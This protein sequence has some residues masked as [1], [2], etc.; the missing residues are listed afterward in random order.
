MLSLLKYFRKSEMVWDDQAEQSLCKVP[1]PM[2]PMVRGKVEE[3]VRQRGGNKVRARDFDEA[4]EAFEQRFK[5]ST[6][7]SVGSNMPAPNE[8]GVPMTLVQACHSRAAGCKN[9]L[10]DTDE[11]KEAVEQ[12]VEESGIS[13]RLRQR[14]TSDTIFMHNKIRFS[15]SGC[16]NGCSRPQIADFGIVGTVTPVFDTEKCTGCGECAEACPDN[17]IA[18]VHD[19]AVR[20]PETC[21]GCLCCSRACPAECIST[22]EPRARLLV[23][24]KLGRHPHLADPAGEFRTPEE[25]LRRVETILEEYLAES[26]PG[27]RFAKYWVEKTREA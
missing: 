16:P 1:A 13:E 5:K 27:E 4:K 6:G 20:D 25:L 15:I 12:W 19:V 24:G 9:P 3:L 18:M 2:R 10:I 22:V 26:E 14:L 7:K 17:A 11:W 21:Q 8:P 23:G